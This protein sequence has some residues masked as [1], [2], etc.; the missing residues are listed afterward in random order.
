M[1]NKGARKRKKKQMR[2]EK[3]REKEEKK[4]KYCRRRGQ[5]RGFGSDSCTRSDGSW[6]SVRKRGIGWLEPTTRRSA[7]A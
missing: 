1:E 3:K 2:K 7:L 5:Q 6:A 4:K